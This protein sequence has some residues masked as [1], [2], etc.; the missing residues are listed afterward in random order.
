[1][2]ETEVELEKVHE[3][4]HEAAHGK[5][6]WIM[7]GALLSALFAV[8]AAVAAL[9][10][11]HHANEA[12][13]DQI[14]ASDQWGYYQAKG[15]KAAILESRH[16]LLRNLGKTP[17]ADTTEKLAKYRD[18]QKEIQDK[19]KE[20]EAASIAHFETHRVL[21]KAVTFFQIAIAVTAIAVLVGKAAF[22]FVSGGFGLVGLAF[23][24]QGLFL[25]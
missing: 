12:V 19:A 18:D 2:E 5:H 11:G 7:A 10:S 6:G 8:F 25:K 14:Q 23:L 16:D 21:A 13:M 4:I 3:H 9:D 24:I 17:D 15:I 22:L 20:K 1:M